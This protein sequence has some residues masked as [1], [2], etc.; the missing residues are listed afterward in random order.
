MRRKVLAVVLGMGLMS[1][2]CACGNRESEGNTMEMIGSESAEANIRNQSVRNSS[3]IDQTEQEAAMTTGYETREIHVDKEGMDIY[4]VVHI[5]SGT[6]G[7]MPTVIMSH[8]LGA[9][10]DR[11]KGYGE[12]LAEEGYVT[13]CFDFCG[14]GWASRSDGELLDM[15]VLTEKADLEAVLEEV[16]QWD[17]VDTGSIYLMGNSQGGLVTALTAAEH[18]EE[19]RAVILIYPAFCIYDD[20]HEMFDSP[21]EIPETHSLL[22]LRLGNRYFVDAWDQEPYER[23]KEYG[24]NILLIHGDRDSIVPISYSD[25]LAETIDH[26]EYHVIRGADHGYLGE[27]FD[28]AVSYIRDFLKAEQAAK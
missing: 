14:G 15:S 2:L 26:V 17:F 13:V 9:T 12:A 28:L 8:E 5:P 3:Q 4:G 25:K 19:I 11:V 20:V 27:D 6:E 21:E 22:G 23:I 10:L 24:K 18:K 16:K 1:A 7:K